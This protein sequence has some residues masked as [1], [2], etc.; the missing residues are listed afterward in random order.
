ME[1]YFKN[2]PFRIGLDATIKKNNGKIFLN[3][4][5][6]R[7][8]RNH[9]SV[10][11]CIAEIMIENKTG[12]TVFVGSIACKWC[13]KMRAWQIIVINK[14]DN[15]LNQEQLDYIKRIVLKYSKGVKYIQR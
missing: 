6:C 2:K 12:R 14:Y 15:E 3:S 13:E 9:K 11:Y 4:Y 7:L 5:S 1:L 8:Y 10:G